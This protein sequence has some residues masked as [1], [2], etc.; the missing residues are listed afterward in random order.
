[1][2]LSGLLVGAPMRMTFH[3]DLLALG[4]S[5][6]VRPDLLVVAEYQ[7]GRTYNGPAR[8]WLSGWHVGAEYQAPQGVAVRAGLNDGEP[9]VG[10]GYARDHWHA[11]YT[12]MKNW[13]DDIAG[14]LFGN[15][16]THQLQA[17]YAW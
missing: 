16:D 6:H 2:D 13:N 9:T 10:L 8:G 15:S 7:Q 17:V 3:T 11:D 5:R 12:Y 4:A 14:A 1:M